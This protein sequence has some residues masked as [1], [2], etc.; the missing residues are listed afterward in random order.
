MNVDVK[1]YTRRSDKQLKEL[2]E[3]YVSFAYVVANAIAAA[4]TFGEY[5]Y[6]TNN[7]RNYCQHLGKYLGITVY[8]FKSTG[9][10]INITRVSEIH[11]KIEADMHTYTY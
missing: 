8:S 6:V 7:C 4:E 3:K 11:R 10:D 1:Q 2:G 9:N 5:N